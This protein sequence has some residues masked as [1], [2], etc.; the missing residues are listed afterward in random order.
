MVIKKREI[1]AKQK[2]KE[3]REMSE[4]GKKGLAR[5]CSAHFY[6]HIIER[7]KKQNPERSKKER[8]INSLYVFIF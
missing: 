6:V 4:L 2:C 1:D 7:E 8:V 5:I 3:K